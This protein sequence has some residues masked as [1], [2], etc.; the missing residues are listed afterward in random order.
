MLAQFAYGSSVKRLFQGVAATLF[1]NSALDSDAM[2]LAGVLMH[3][4]VAFTWSA[5][6]L[7]LHERSAGVR[8]VVASPL[9]V[10]KV[11]AVFGPL[12]WT[13]MSLIV[14]P[15]LTGRPPVITIRWWNQFVGHAIFVGLP[16]VSMIADQRPR[17]KAN[18]A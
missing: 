17:L 16:I 5:I 9:G 11:A 1:G 14:I 18:N 6:F 2:A 12:V 15:T 8:R 3:V 4:G 7:I 13:V 10:L